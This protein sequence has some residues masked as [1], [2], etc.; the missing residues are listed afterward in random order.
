VSDLRQPVIDPDNLQ[1]GAAAPT[2]VVLWVFRRAFHARF[3][4]RDASRQRCPENPASRPGKPLT[5][6]SFPTAARAGDRRDM[7]KNA[8]TAFNS[9][10][11]PC[12]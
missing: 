11:P 6:R 4:D 5:V 1:H 10:V 3:T 7:V 12:R 9:V 8:L 2:A